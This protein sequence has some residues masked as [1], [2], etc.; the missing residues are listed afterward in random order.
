MLMV[1]GYVCLFDMMYFRIGDDLA[2]G[3]N[4]LADLPDNEFVCGLRDCFVCFICFSGS[5]KTE[6]FGFYFIY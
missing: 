5:R 3:E 2:I 6:F 1:Y 4:N